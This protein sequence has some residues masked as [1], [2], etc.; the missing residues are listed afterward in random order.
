MNIYEYL[1]INRTAQSFT[2][3]QQ[4]LLRLLHTSQANTG[5]PMTI[6]NR[7]TAD[8][9]QWFQ[10]SQCI[11]GSNNAHLLRYVVKNNERYPI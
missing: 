4:P 7:H 3:S 10:I 5:Q 11:S 9:D 6:N 2:R 8:R 1:S